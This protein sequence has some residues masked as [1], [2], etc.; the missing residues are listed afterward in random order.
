M[1]TYSSS[2]DIPCAVLSISLDT[3]DT[4]V[5]KKSSERKDF[6]VSCTATCKG[7]PPDDFFSSLVLRR[8]PDCFEKVE[9]GRK[10]SRK[11]NIS[12]HF[13]FPSHSS[14]VFVFTT[15]VLSPVNM[16]LAPWWFGTKAGEWVTLRTWLIVTISPMFYFGNH[17]FL[18]G[19][20]GVHPLAVGRNS[21]MAKEYKKGARS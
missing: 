6:W 18:A 3:W 11:R 15:Q 2:W 8:H 21:L 14:T 13:S 7:P 9:W 16:C 20:E 10:N 5:K 12:F 1:T 4:M 19:T 17:R